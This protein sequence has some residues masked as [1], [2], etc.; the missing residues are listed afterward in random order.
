MEFFLLVNYGKFYQWNY[1]LLYPSIN[2][3][4]NIL[5]VYIEG[6]VVEKEWIKKTEKYDDV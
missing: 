4:E 3:S 1:L 6:I 5:L 2:T